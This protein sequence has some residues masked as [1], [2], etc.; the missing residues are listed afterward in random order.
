MADKDKKLQD[1]DQ[2]LIGVIIGAVGLVLFV[3]GVVGAL[4]V[5]FLGVIGV[6][7][8]V[9]VYFVGVSNKKK[10]EEV[11][12]DLYPEGEDAGGESS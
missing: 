3:L 11:K 6:I 9:I 8:G 10:W 4:R 12:K 2:R 7:V 1:L 5:T